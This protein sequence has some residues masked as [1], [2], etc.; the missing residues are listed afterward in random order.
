MPTLSATSSVSDLSCQGC[1]HPLPSRQKKKCRAFA[2]RTVSVVRQALETWTGIFGQ[3]T[4]GFEPRFCSCTCLAKLVKAMIQG[5]PSSVEEER[6]AFQSIKKL[7]PD[8]CSCMEPALLEGIRKKF[9]SRGPPLPTGYLDFVR[10]TTRKLFPKGWDSSYVKFCETLSPPISASEGFSR[11]AGGVL[12]AGLDHDNIMEALF[13][14]LDFDP[15][16]FEGQPVYCLNPEKPVKCAPDGI[17]CQALV[18]QSAGKP[19][20]L[21]KFKPESILLKPLHKTIYGWLSAKKWLLRGEVTAE[22]LRKAGFVKDRGCLVSGDYASATDNLPI[23]VVEVILDVLEKNA[24]F[25]PQ[26]IFSYARKSL[27]PRMWCFDPSTETDWEIDVVRGQMMGSLLSFPMLCL[28]NFMG[29]SFAVSRAGKEMPPCLINGDDILFQSDE[30][31]VPYWMEVVAKLGLEVEPTKTS[32]STEYGSINSTLVRWEENHLNVIHTLRFGQLRRSE[33]PTSLAQSFFS[34][35]GK[36]RALPTP[37]RWKAACAYFSWHAAELRDKSGVGFYP[38]ELG[39]R[40][41]LAFRLCDRYG[42]FRN[43]DPRDQIRSPPKG[44]LVHNVEL[45][46]DSCTL[47]SR[48]D[49]GEEFGREIARATAVW[50]WGLD[51]ESIREG[52]ARWA[53]ALSCPARWRSRPEGLQGFNVEPRLLGT[54]LSREPDLVVWR[55]RFRRP[56]VKEDLWPVLDAALYEQ[57]QQFE[58]VPSYDEAIGTLFQLQVEEDGDRGKKW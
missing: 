25:C 34:F 38:D 9:S 17:T 52:Q 36:P 45:P 13:G 12:G 33:N 50:K 27:R 37:V 35:L 44:H 49:F 8:S 20:P 15:A 46:S 24:I 6:M 3:D 29:L 39:F 53:L 42:L 32:V 19:R 18:V 58:P 2:K 40:G 14:R 48:G 11:T 22:K 54:R 7:L 28:Q 30:A 16:K 47:V 5:C 56:W 21:S 31:F 51:F 23:E 1:G 4:V 57:M 10:K 55:R 43:R 41:R 26:S